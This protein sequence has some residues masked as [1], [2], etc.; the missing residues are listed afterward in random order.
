MLT[1]EI[2][3]CNIFFLNLGDIL[4][5][6]VTISANLTKKKNLKDFGT[7]T[8]NFFTLVC[9]L[10]NF[11]LPVFVSKLMLTEKNGASDMKQ[12]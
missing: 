7:G 1:N 11:V 9:G 4:V 2:Q 5:G 10:F 8:C 3:I 12:K 6:K